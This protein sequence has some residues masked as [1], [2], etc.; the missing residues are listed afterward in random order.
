MIIQALE[1]FFLLSVKTK[2]DMIYIHAKTIE[3]HYR[4]TNSIRKTI[5]DKPLQ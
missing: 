5:M 3:E 2:Q 4:Y 1:T